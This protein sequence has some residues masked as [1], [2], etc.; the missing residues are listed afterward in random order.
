MEE[1][2]V[3]LYDVIFLRRSVR[4]YSFEELSDKKIKEIKNVISSVES[5]Y[6]DINLKINIIDREK[7]GP[8]LKGIVGNYGKIKAPYYLSAASE[9]KD[10]YLENTGFVLEKIVL[11]L[12]GMGVGTCWIGSK[13]DE[14]Q[15]R[16]ITGISNN[17]KP[18]I[19]IA[20]GYPEVHNDLYR[21]HPSEARRKDLHSIVAGNPGEEWEKILSA[22]KLAPSSVNSQPWRFVIEDNEIHV[23]ISS[24]ILTKHFLGGLNQID[25]GIALRHAEI[26][27]EHYSK[28]IEFK[29]L[30]YKYQPGLKYITS[31]IEK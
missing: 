12:T 31:I 15:L 21:K 1:L 25:A 2:I 3:E 14:E 23:Y 6:K 20:F 26:A 9:V 27:A 19:L 28:N 30:S 13:V 7:I 4:K 10:G 8:I 16:A 18:V 17:L 29:K 11:S 5:L 22:V 24:N